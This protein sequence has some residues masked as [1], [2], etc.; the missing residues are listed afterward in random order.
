MAGGED[1]GMEGKICLKVISK[2]SL[3]HNSGVAAFFKMLARIEF[4]MV[5][6][7]ICNFKAEQT[8]SADTKSRAP[9]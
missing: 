4:E 3:S 2:P 5:Q 6:G 8:N 9:D 7:N 1:D